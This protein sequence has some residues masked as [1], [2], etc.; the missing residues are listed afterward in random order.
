MLARHGLRTVALGY[1]T[2]ILAAPVAMIFWRTFEHGLAPVWHALSDPRT[3]H[4]L[5]LTLL[6]VAVA[7]PLNTIFGVA[8][9]LLIV[10]G[11]MRG[12]AALN[13]VLDLPFA[14]SPVVVGLAL[15][16][17]YGRNGWAGDWLLGHGVQ[18]LFSPLG[19]I[20]PPPSSR[21]RSWCAR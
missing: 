3:L 10:R 5:K 12:K 2:A 16:L 4:A 18:V 15:L 20:L 17:V 9:A 7:V 14:V 19:M 1:L 13:A 21:C 6:M 11:R 8:C